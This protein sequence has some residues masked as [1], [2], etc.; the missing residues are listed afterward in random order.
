VPVG[1]FFDLVAEFNVS[2]CYTPLPFWNS[3]TCENGMWV[4]HGNVTVSKPDLVYS[5][6]AVLNDGELTIETDL[7]IISNLTTTSLQMNTDSNV[8]LYNSQIGVVTSTCT[9]GGNLYLN[10]TQNQLMEMKAYPLLRTGQFYGQFD[11][12]YL[13]Q[14]NSAS[15]EPA[16]VDV[17]QDKLGIVLVVMCDAVQLIKFGVIPLLF[18]NL[19]ILYIV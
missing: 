8:Y 15:Y 4:S 13:L 9:I 17:Q 14:D 6:S 1:N 3:I 7:S 16:C 11:T 5:A 19:V 12:V 18:F 10:I 2:Y